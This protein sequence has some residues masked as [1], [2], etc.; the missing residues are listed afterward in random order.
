MMEVLARGGT[1]ETAVVPVATSSSA[2]G[3][4]TLIFQ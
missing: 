3:V 4:P 1:I 2:I